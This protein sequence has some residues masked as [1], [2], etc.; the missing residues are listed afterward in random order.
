MLRLASFRTDHVARAAL[1]ALGAL[2]WLLAGCATG[3]AAQAP[4][5]KAAAAPPVPA[6][7]PLGE[8]LRRR[9]ALVPSPAGEAG[10]TRPARPDLQ[11]DALVVAMAYVG[12]PYRRGGSDYE[13]GVD[14]SGF[15]QIAYRE[16]AGVVLPR[17]AAEQ[18]AAT[19][20][21]EPEDLR[22]GDLVF[23]NTLGRP[24]SHV[25]LYVGQGR[26]VH[27][28]RPGA[29]VRLERLDGSYWRARF[30]GARRVTPGAALQARAE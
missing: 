25:G 16:G 17:T 20:P 21:I 3:G 1:A 14:C 10:P 22:P 27:S 13:Q 6:D 19:Q 8:W 23:F 24:F 29:Q 9:D 2:A 4:A 18:A 5:A 28:P 15:V 7:D 26:F 11:A 12:V 30:D